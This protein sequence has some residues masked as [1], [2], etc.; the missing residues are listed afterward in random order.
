LRLDFPRIPTT[1]DL[2]LFWK[3]VR[4]G[5]KLRILHI[6]GVDITPKSS[7]ESNECN[8]VETV[9][10]DVIE[11]RLYIN[12]ESFFTKISKEVYNFTVGGYPICSKYLKDRKGRVLS[13][14]E[15]AHLINTFRANGI[16]GMSYLADLI[17]VAQY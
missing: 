1:T 5:N 6:N 10:Y 9:R 4:L 14:E 8:I 11:E 15:I 2:T 7:F 13:K 12:K 17:L 16:C 3:L